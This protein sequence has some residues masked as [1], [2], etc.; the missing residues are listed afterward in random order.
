ME[1]TDLTPIRKRNPKTSR[2]LSAAIEKALA[3]HPDDRFQ[4]A[5]EFK[6]ALLNS[7]G[8]T[9]RKIAEAGTLPPESFLEENDFGSN[10]VLDPD[11]G[12]GDSA[13]SGNSS[14]PLPVSESL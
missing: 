13:I 4:S 3:V 6:L 12:S 11:S 10:L 8:I 7:R 2:R 1:Q 14:L 5:K 9:Q